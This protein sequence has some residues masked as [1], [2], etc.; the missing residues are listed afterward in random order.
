MHPFHVTLWILALL[1]PGLSGCRVSASA[2]KAQ[3][4]RPTEMLPVLSDTCGFGPLTGLIGQDFAELA[5][6]DLQD[7]RIIAPGQKVTDQL[8]PSRLNAEVDAIGRIRR[9]YCG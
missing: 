8:S 3:I 2:E 4:G 5:A 6:A 9:L 1:V 7:L